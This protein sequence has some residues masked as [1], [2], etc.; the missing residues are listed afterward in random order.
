LLEAP[1]VRGNYLGKNF[2]FRWEAMILVRIL[3]EELHNNIGWNIKKE[4]GFDSL[5]IKERK[6]DFV[7]ILFPPSLRE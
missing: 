1:L 2:F 5:G 3:Y 4:V 7:P 6:E